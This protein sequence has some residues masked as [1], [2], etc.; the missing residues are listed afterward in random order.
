MASKPSENPDKPAGESKPIRKIGRPTNYRP[1][2]CERVVELGS[3]GYSVAM[4]I[5]DIGAGSRQTISEWMK[6]HREFGDAMTRARDLA[7]AWWERKGLENTGNRDLLERRR[8]AQYSRMADFMLWVAACEGALWPAGTFETAYAEKRESMVDSVL[9]SDPVANAIRGFVINSW[10][11]TA[12][13]LLKCLNDWC[14]N[15]GVKQ[16]RSFPTTPGTLSGRIR[17]AAPFLRKVGFEVTFHPKDSTG[18]RHLTISRK[19]A[20]PP[21]PWVQD[22]LPF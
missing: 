17:R 22:D 2:F 11:G 10:R 21:P 15:N 5:A 6:A 1:E 14:I 8:L 13:D 19:D 20:P 3:Q 7:L 9:E 4:I 18:A 12:S 16:T